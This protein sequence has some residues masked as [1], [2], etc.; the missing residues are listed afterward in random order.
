MLYRDDVCSGDEQCRIK[1]IFIKIAFIGITRIR[2]R[3][4]PI[5][6]TIRDVGILKRLHP[7]EINNRTCI[8]SQLHRQLK[9]SRGVIN[10]EFLPEIRHR[11]TGRR[12]VH[13]G[14]DIDGDHSR[15]LDT[16]IP[17]R[18][19]SSQPIIINLQ[20]GPP[21]CPKIPVLITV[22]PDAFQRNQFHIENRTILGSCRRID[23][24]P[25][26][27]RVSAIG[28]VVNQPGFIG[29]VQG[30]PARNSPTKL[31][32]LRGRSPGP[33]IFI[34]EILPNRSKKIP[35]STRSRTSPGKRLGS[36]H[37]LVIHHAEKIR[38]LGYQLIH[39]SLEMGIGVVPII[40][41]STIE[42]V[43]VDPVGEK[44]LEFLPTIQPPP[45]IT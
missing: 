11:L 4:C 2:G 31:T 36:L 18:P 42:H 8:G 32:K 30:S 39:F 5:G 27:T 19:R 13:L 29:E 28:R 6:R 20:T 40:E 35:T 24:P 22:A 43:L 44:N 14:R 25:R 3:K 21:C 15:F 33:E 23:P 16:A 9:I 26:K 1:S 10:L 45:K 17:Q 7:I 37:P 41:N 34:V 12:I 38:K